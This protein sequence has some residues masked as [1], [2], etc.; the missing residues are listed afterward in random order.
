MSP[1]ARWKGIGNK[2]C[3]EP[4]PIQPPSAGIVIAP[5]WRVL[6][7]VDIDSAH[8]IGA[9]A[10][11]TIAMRFA[12]DYPA[13]TRTLSV[14]SGPASVPP[15]VSFFT[16]PSQIP[17]LDRLGS[18]ASK[19]M[20]DYWDNMFKTAAEI[21]TKGPRAAITDLAKDGVLQRIKAPTLVMTA[22]RSKTQSVEQARE[23]QKLIPNSRLVVLRSD[24]YHIA[25][26][27]ADECVTNVLAFIKEARHKA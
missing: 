3:P 21:P 11:G 19:E 18:A 14:V 24:A 2:D 10:G 16:N 20:V 26:V 15:T 1:P 8:I 13:R 9:K 27:N 4:R 22:D 6:D 23:Y 7:K 12:A 5:T 17:Q 25:A